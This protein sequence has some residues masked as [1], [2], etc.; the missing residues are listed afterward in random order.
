MLDKCCVPGAAC[1][2]MVE[3]AEVVEEVEEVEEED[4]LT[5]SRAGGAC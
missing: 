2:E 5:P 1:R 4:T 3:V